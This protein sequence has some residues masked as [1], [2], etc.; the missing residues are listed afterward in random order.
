MYLQNMQVTPNSGGFGQHQQGSIFSLF[1]KPQN[2]FNS[3]NTQA[4]IQINKE[5]FSTNNSQQSIGSF[6][7]QNLSFFNQ[8]PQ[9][10]VNAAQQTFN[11]NQPQ[12]S[13]QPANQTSV[14][15]TQQNSDL[16]EENIKQYLADSFTLN[17]VPEIAPPSKYCQ[18]ILYYVFPIKYRYSRFM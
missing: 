18:K 5:Q 10:N 1:N 6:P 4:Q 17:S 9:P 14:Q 11:F 12:Q 3:V 8:V 15:A 7:Q 2:P 13:L 16:T